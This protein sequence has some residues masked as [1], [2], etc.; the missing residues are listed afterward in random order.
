MKRMDG[1]ATTTFP[2]LCSVSNSDRGEGLAFVVS[3]GRV[4]GMRK[5]S[6]RKVHQN[7]VEG[8]EHTYDFRSHPS[9][10][11]RSSTAALEGRASELRMK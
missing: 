2:A 8:V 11:R 1:A 6:R 4:H 7:H 3:T 9:V 10:Y 5:F